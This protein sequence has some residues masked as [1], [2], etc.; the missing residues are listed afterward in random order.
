MMTQN[1]SLSKPYS[2]LH[3]QSLWR[4]IAIFNVN[5]SNCERSFSLALLQHT[6]K[7][8]SNLDLAL[9]RFSTISHNMTICGKSC[10]HPQNIYNHPYHPKKTLRVLKLF[11]YNI[12]LPEAITK[13]GVHQEVH[14]VFVC[15]LPFAI[16]SLQQ[17]CPLRKRTLRS[18]MYWKYL[19]FF[20]KFSIP[21]I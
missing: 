20:K 14:S 7:I 12:K 21:Q 16:F 17:C 2:I 19:K 18:L 4:L 10:H 6:I 15:R 8:A 13:T 11:H 1:L 9:E 5:L 3:Y